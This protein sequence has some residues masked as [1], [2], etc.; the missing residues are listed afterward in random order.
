MRV[1]SRLL[2]A[3][4]IAGLLIPLAISP[5][6]AAVDITSFKV[7]PDKGPVGTEVVLEGDAD[8]DDEGWVYYELIPEGDD[9]V[10]LLDDSD[11][12]GFED[13]TVG[14]PPVTYWDFE[15]EEFTIPESPGGIHR[16]AIVDDD[17][18]KTADADDVKDARE[19]EREF[20]VLPKVE[21]VSVNGEDCDPDE[22]E[23][24]AGAEVEVKGT[25]FG[26]DEE[27]IQ[28]YFGDDKIEVEM[29]EEVDANELGTWTG[30][31][32]VPR[33]S[34]GTHEILAGGDDTD[35]DDVIAAYFTIEPGITVSPASGTVGS[36]FTVAGSGFEENENDIVILFD[37][38]VVSSAFDAGSDGTFEVTVTV[39]E[40]A[41]GTH[42][43]DAKGD[44]TKASEVKDKEFEVEPSLVMEPTSGNVGTQIEV[45]GKGLPANTSVTV[46]YDGVTKGTGTTNSKGTLAG[47]TFAATHTQSV[48]TTDHTIAATFDSTTLNL[49]FEIES[50][51]PPKPVPGTPANGT[52][53]GLVGN[54]TVTLTWGVVDDPSGV[55]YGLQ[56][57]AT[58]DFSQ[59]LISKSGLVAQGSALI[60]SPTGPE[61]SYTLTESEALPY[62]TYY[63]RVKAVDGALNDSGW[64]ASNNFK[65]GLL[66]TWAL[67]VIIVLAAILVGALIYVL[68]IR[69]RVGLYD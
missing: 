4:I 17:L 53:I 24:T 23:G 69:D 45:M 27:D 47:I 31:F 39:P 5:V 56:V 22:A 10:K 28:I 15:T 12:W 38:D 36:T 37:G 63:W 1:V 18:G 66:P 9:W 11:D 58:P 2:A 19:K 42:D 64:S 57:S 32:I 67:I 40:A 33:T 48:H 55:T 52:R 16:I 61:M 68:I 7:H 34:A 8:D 3:V 13:Y 29:V 20:E 65:V 14:D 54:Q 21:L 51:P 49:T 60:V 50:T 46:T 59:V 25:G 6:A 35:E 43:I 44:D 62:G 30:T 26:E 41:M